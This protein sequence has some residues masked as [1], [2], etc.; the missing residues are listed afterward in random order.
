MKRRIATNVL[1]AFHDTVHQH[2]HGVPDLAAAIGMV[3]GT[4]YNKAN[5]NDD[6]HPPTLADAILVMGRTGNPAIA[7]A[8]S[9]AAGG[10]YVPLPAVGR[11]TDSAQL[12]EIVSRWMSEQ[13]HFFAE[14]Q[15]AIADGHVSEREHAAVERRAR[16]VVAGCLELVQRLQS[17]GRDE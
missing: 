6:R 17:G 16:K 9:H 13:G 5:V 8:I 12:F 4:L 10:V 3:P 2:E 7:Q 15:S 14:F 11:L 1:E